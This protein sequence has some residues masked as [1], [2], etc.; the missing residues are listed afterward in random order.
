MMAV[1]YFIISW[2]M[3]LLP[4][5]CIVSQQRDSLD[6]AM[7][8]W[9]GTTDSEKG[10]ID[11]FT[12]K[13]L[14]VRFI[15]YDCKN[16]A[17]NLAAIREQLKKN[18]PDLIYSF[19][20]TVTTTLIGRHNNHPS[21]LYITDVPTVFAVVADPEGAGIIAKE[22]SLSRRNVTGVSHLVPFVLQL[23]AIRSVI[24]IHSIGTLYNPEEKNAILQIRQLSAES[25][26]EKY[27]LHS[28]PLSIS[29]NDEVTMN[30]LKQTIQELIRIKPDI[31]YLPSDSYLISNADTIVSLFHEARIPCFSATEEPIT[32]SGAYMGLVSRYYLVGMFAGYKAHQILFQKL[33]P[34]TIPVERLKKFSFLLNIDAAH[35][36]DIFPPVPLLRFAEIVHTSA[37]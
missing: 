1:R 37:D 25:I 29:D 26:P 35:Y 14:P 6:I 5:A 27:V 18:P 31:I 2:F 9:R 3:I 7:V 10:F 33:D 20:T 19:G 17:E 28:R 15:V 11:Y 34:G 24:A 36:L 30:R 16:E 21:K 32:K 23:R 4:P 12:K 22:D 8:L 13:S